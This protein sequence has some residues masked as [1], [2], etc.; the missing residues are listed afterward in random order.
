MKWNIC[1]KQGGDEKLEKLNEIT[2][3]YINQNGLMI[4]HFADYIGGS[5]SQA[6]HWLHG[7]RKLSV[8]QLKR[9]HEF[10]C[11]KHI[12]TAEQILKED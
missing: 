12:K 6:S 11:G 1:E 8:E 3:A 2:L 10:L 7:D 9:V 5:Y 4:N